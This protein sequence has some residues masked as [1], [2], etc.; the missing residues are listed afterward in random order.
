MKYYL[1]LFL[2]TISFSIMAQKEINTSIKINA[3]AEKVWQ[4]LTAFEAYPNWNPFL[5]SVQG[6]FVV[7]KKVKIVA[8]GMKFKPKVLQYSENKGIKWIG[9]L[10]FKGLFDGE[11]SFQIQ[12][13]QDGTST[14]YHSEKFSGM[15]VGLFAKKLD[16]E[17][18]AG[19][20]A[21]NKKL[22]ELAEGDH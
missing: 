18:K 3:S 5:T 11:H 13:H 4:V 1:S 21:M 14:F 17:T 22:K 12:D 6:D 20:E 7:G 2:I 15:L 10:L 19:F 8:G 9:R 16:T